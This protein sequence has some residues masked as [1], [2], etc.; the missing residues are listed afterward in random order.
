MRSA[1]R[2][3]RSSVRVSRGKKQRNKAHENGLVFPNLVTMSPMRCSTCGGAL[4]L[5]T[6]E[7]CRER[8]LGLVEG[9]RQ[10][11]LAWLYT[12]AHRALRLA[13]VY[14]GQDGAASLRARGCVAQVKVYRR[15][16][17]LLRTAF[18]HGVIGAAGSATTNGAMPTIARAR[19]AG[20]EP[21]QSQRSRA[22]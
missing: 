5:E 8:E 7:A 20:G 1:E 12:C 6:C 11:K 9:R 22:G 17:R 10:Q 4:E 15:D 16:I 3:F 2:P 21:A 14:L 13:R 18:S 19:E